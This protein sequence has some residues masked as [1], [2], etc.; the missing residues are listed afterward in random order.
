MSR[1]P[2]TG[3]YSSRSH[4]DDRNVI[5]DRYNPEQVQKM[6]T[7][8]V[9]GQEELFNRIKAK[10]ETSWKNMRDTI[11]NKGLRNYKA[12]NFFLM[13]R[14][15]KPARLVGVWRGTWRVMLEG[16]HV[17]IVEDLRPLE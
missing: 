1:Q 12:G 4:N 11:H 7:E 3:F 14:P 8:L 13:A 5:V 16:R 15:R 9:C 10:V 2:R 6:V 17:H